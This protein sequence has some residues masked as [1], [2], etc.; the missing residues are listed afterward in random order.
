MKKTPE[1][2]QSILKL[3][4]PSSETILV[5]GH[6]INLW[7]TAYQDKIPELQNYLPFSSEDLDFIGG[8]IEANEFQEKLG[9]TL[10]FPRKF[11]AS[12]NTAILTTKSGSDD[13]RIDF[14]GNVFGL[15]TEQIL[16]SAVSFNSNKLPGVNLKVLNPILCVSGKLKSYTGL[17]QFGRQDKKHLEIAILTARQYVTEICQSN[18]PRIG[19]RSI[20]RLIKI[21]KSEAG[22]RVWQEDKLDIL[23]TIPQ[24]AINSLQKEQWQRFKQMRMPQVLQEIELKRNKYQQIITNRSVTNK[25][26]KNIESSENRER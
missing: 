10:I 5:G 6:A 18:P 3:I 21:A 13:L 15:D 9:G 22:L 16:S 17:P 11:S 4:S 20:E 25:K 1:E 14:L 19:L 23:N 26:P 2:I 7:A 12:P 8:K 24:E